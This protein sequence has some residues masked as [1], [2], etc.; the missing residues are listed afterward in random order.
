MSHITTTSTTANPILEKIKSD[1]LYQV[2]QAY[3][4]TIK[5]K[6]G[7]TPSDEVRDNF[8]LTCVTFKLNPLKK[9]IYLLGYDRK[10]GSATFN[11]IVS[12]SGFTAIASRTGEFAGVDQPRFI[13]N[14]QKLDSCSVT[15]YRLIQGQRCAF[16][17][18]AYYDERAN[19]QFGIK[20]QFKEQPKTML[21]KCARAAAL[22]IA[23]PEELG[24][25]YDIDEM[26]RDEAPSPILKHLTQ[27]Q[28]TSLDAIIAEHASLTEPPTTPDAVKQAIQIKYNIKSIQ[29]LT[30]DQYEEVCKR[31]QLAINKLTSNQ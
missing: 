14:D 22:R 8:I 23:F 13:Y 17:G 15:V 1:P 24:N 28:L 16:T 7:K 2:V 12:A 6:L 30:S 5:T 3:L 21:E 20:S 29:E 25:K 18:N 10:D 19:D 9:Q 4:D 11:E 31:L 26:P 27:S